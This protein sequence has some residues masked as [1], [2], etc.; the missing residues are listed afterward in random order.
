M[1]NN[2]SKVTQK[3]KRHCGTHNKT[4]KKE[5][6]VNILKEIRDYIYKTRIRIGNYEK[7]RQNFRN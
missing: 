5:P 7:Q 1:K 4:Y 3:S 2:N 6:E